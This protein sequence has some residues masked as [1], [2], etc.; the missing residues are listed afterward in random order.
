M[1]IDVPDEAWLA[2]FGEILLTASVDH[3]VIMSDR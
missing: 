1:L 2:D 3:T